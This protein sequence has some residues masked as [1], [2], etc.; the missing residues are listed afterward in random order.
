MAG[1]G[2]QTPT[3]DGDFF[4]ARLWT[5][6]VHDHAETRVNTRRHASDLI[7][8]LA[9]FTSRTL[10]EMRPLPPF[11]R[12][13]EAG[14]SSLRPSTNLRS[15]SPRRLPT[16]ARSAKV[17]CFLPISSFGWQANLLRKTSS[18]DDFFCVRRRTRRAPRSCPRR[19][20]T[21]IKPTCLRARNSGDPAATPAEAPTAITFLLA[22]ALSTTWHC[23]HQFR[24]VTAISARAGF[25]LASPAQAL[26]A[27]C[28]TL[29]PCQAPDA[30]PQ[31]QDRPRW[32]TE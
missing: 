29:A 32:R 5:T 19:S 6:G 27:E 8:G 10:N 11:V 25:L 16:V 14:S 20:D 1:E 17:G 23:C 21:C 4:V 3:A 13:A 7:R 2:D 31:N 26:Y 30:L 18:S 9:A 28:C 12:N 24:T 15:R 22:R